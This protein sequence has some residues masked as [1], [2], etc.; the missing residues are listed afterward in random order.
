[1][2]YFRNIKTKVIKDMKF[3]KLLK[4]GHVEIIVRGQRTM[5]FPCGNEK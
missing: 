2:G 3:P 1:M 4:K 5:E